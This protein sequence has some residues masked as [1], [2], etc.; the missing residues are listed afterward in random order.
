MGQHKRRLQWVPVAERVPRVHHRVVADADVDAR[1]EQLLHPSVA[2]PDGVAVETPLQRRVVERV[3]DHMHLGALQVVDEL[4]RV[5]VVVR[6]HC[7]GVT[8]R[9]STPQAQADS[10]RGDHLDET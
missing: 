8:G 3:G 10:F 7:G 6:V 1:G 2:A 9:H 4:V 5:S